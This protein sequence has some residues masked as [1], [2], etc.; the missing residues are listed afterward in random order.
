MTGL[1]KDFLQCP[2]SGLHFL[3]IAIVKSDILCLFN[4]LRALVQN[5][6]GLRVQGTAQKNSFIS[7]DIKLVSILF[8]VED[9]A[10]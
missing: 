3:D 2:F 8:G 7:F 10:S 1:W 4:L 9:E 6:I 5:S